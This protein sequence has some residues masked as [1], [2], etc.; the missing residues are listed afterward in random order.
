MTSIHYLPVQD[1]IKRAARMYKRLHM[2]Q[3]IEADKWVEHTAAHNRGG[4]QG[5]VLET[6]DARARVL[7]SHYRDRPSAHKVRTWVRFS[8]LRVIPPIE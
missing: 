4:R 3:V 8:D 2:S 7:W 1:R 6:K 5:K